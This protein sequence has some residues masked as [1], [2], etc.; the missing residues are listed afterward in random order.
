MDQTSS[1]VP[2]SAPSL[3]RRRVRSLAALSIVLL[4]ATVA[5]AGPGPIGPE[6][7][8]DDRSV[9]ARGWWTRCADASGTTTSVHPS[10][11][12]DECVASDLIVKRI[13][14]LGVPLEPD[15]RPN[16][17]PARM[18][19]F[20]VRCAASGEFVVQWQDAT[21]YCFMHRVYNAGGRAA[22][23]P[24]QTIA[25]DTACRVRPAV[26]LDPAGGIVAVW[27]VRQSHARSTIVGRRFG[28]DG[29]GD[30]D[31]FEVSDDVVE[32]VGP[33][34]KVAVDEDGLAL[35]SWVHALEAEGPDAI[36]ARL[37][38]GAGE[39]VGEVVRLNTFEHGSA[40]GPAVYAEE[41][42]R[43]VVLWSNLL[44]G[45]RVGRRFGLIAD[46][47]VPTTTTT[48][49]TLPER[50]PHFGAARVLTSTV[51]SLPESA[52]PSVDA[53]SDGDWLLTG[54]DA[55]TRRT[56]DDGRRWAPPVSSPP[57]GAR[58]LALASDGA[59]VWVELHAPV[60]GALEAAR[61][62]DDASSWAA[63]AAVGA[64]SDACTDCATAR[65]AV[66]GSPRREW[67]AAWSVRTSTGVEIRAARSVDGARRWRP[68][69]VVA[70]DSGVGRAGFD[71]AT[72]GEGGWVMMWADADLW[73]ARSTDGGAS[74]SPPQP[75]ARRIVCVTCSTHV[76]YDRLEL[77][78]D[79]GGNWL[80]TFA[81]PAYDSDRYGFDADVF[82]VRS[83]DDGATWTSPEPLTAV[84]ERDGAR[85]LDP[86][87]AVDVSE[88]VPRWV[89]AW[90]SYRPRTGA[91][92]MDGDVLSVVSVDAGRTW[93]LP[94]A[95]NEG[96]GDD[97]AGD[98]A[99]RIDV[100][101]AGVW[102]IVW[103]QELFEPGIDAIAVRT[104]AAAAEATCGDDDLE[105]GEQCD[106]GNRLDDDGCDSNCTLTACGNGVPTSTEECDDA[107]IVDEDLCLLDCRLAVCGDGVVSTLVEECDDGNRSNKDACTN[108]CR[109]ARCGDGYKHRGVEECD[110]GNAIDDDA[111]TGLCTLPRCG[112]GI[113]HADEECDDGND[114][115]LDFCLSDCTDAPPR[116]GDGRHDDGEECDDGN[117]DDDDRCL[118]DC[119]RPPPRCG[120]G[121][122][123][124]GEQCDDGDDRNDDNCV[125][126]C[127]A[128]VCGDGY[129]NRST[130]VCDWGDP[131]QADLCGPTCGVVDVC[132]DANGDGLSTVTDAHVILQASVGL[133]AVCPTAACDM[134]GSGAVVVT[135]AKMALDKAVG[136]EVG[137]R[138]SLGTG[139]IVF[140]TDWVGVLG[141][142]QLDVEY[143][144]T[145]GQFRGHGNQVICESLLASMGSG[146]IPTVFNDVDDA[147]VLRMGMV[148]IDGFAGPTDLVRCWFDLPEGVEGVNLVVRTVDAST[149]DPTP[150]FDIFV[151]YRLGE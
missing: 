63:R 82:V 70:S 67:V 123:D 78:T 88:G 20:R 148:S 68:S 62:I 137:E 76:R 37:V 75:V 60:G 48:T 47:H 84:F 12:F 72:D 121:F 17:E 56:I 49:V 80:A 7:P 104:M 135:D 36:H 132:G 65:A 6:F 122:V 134:D 26:A 16:R 93:S 106:D 77:A 107:N 136:F 44:Q 59:G 51:M 149:V 3:R 116:C 31:V 144:H 130:E 4:T 15:I 85:D 66:A 101:A 52:R 118:T 13:D 38:D 61:S 23:E 14:G 147:G 30:G 42:G 96:A 29:G 45:G 35:V 97:L 71:I 21:S 39:P 79:G 141:A 41:A 18:A 90:T 27:P 103:K 124:E 128:A 54:A 10:C 115:D 24:E 11:D 81:A 133:P 19:G 83:S 113:V 102:M 143:G 50:M 1:G 33:K 120:D 105:V 108:R 8:A 98:L 74:W 34:P 146:A 119:T 43:F 89:V 145:G 129:V 114:D 22:G 9:P 127:R 87:L 2:R 109:E 57:G 117:D 110:D 25:D 55:S 91:A 86:T 40:S 100:S 73:V 150:V 139:W 95:V 92:D 5:A 64:V 94:V 138:C 131:D 140:W 28:S 53:G 125:E 58:R 32:G 142:L 99:P 151:G 69:V 112:D 46:D 126:G 111:C